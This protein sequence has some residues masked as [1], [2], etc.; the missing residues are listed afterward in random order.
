MSFQD[1]FSGH[2]R[3]YAAA[4]P[5]YPEALFDWLGIAIGVGGA[6]HQIMFAGCGVPIELPATPGI[7]ADRSVQPSVVPMTIDP[8]FDFHDRRA[9][10]RP[11][12]PED[13]D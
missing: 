6:A 8:H 1:H 12:S 10:A 4:R 7:A 13:L 3:H 11:R 5:T 9:V 2:A